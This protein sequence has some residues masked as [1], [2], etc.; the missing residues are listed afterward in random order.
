MERITVTHSNLRLPTLFIAN[1]ELEFVM[2]G[3]ERV[4]ESN[5]IKRCFC[6]FCATYL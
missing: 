3:V 5:V 4:P 1:K 6:V 2:S